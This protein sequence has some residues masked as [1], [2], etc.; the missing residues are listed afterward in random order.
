MSIQ[1]VTGDKSEN[2]KCYFLY[3]EVNVLGFKVNRHGIQ[4]LEEIVN[5]P[6]PKTNCWEIIFGDDLI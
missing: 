5:L 1:E 4:P 3:D 2:I 6:I